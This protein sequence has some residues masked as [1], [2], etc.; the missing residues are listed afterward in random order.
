MLIDQHN[1]IRD[2]LP[3][4][5]SRKQPAFAGTCKIDGQEIPD[6]IIAVLDISVPLKAG[7]HYAPNDTTLV[8][9]ISAWRIDETRALFVK[10]PLAGL[11]CP[12]NS[13]F[14]KDGGP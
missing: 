13:I 14:T 1:V 9:A 3:F 4:V 5:H 2:V 11:L 8:P 6:E 7:Q 10:F 12:R